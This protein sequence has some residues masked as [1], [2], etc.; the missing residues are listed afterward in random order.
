MAASRTALLASAARS[1][2]VSQSVRLFSAESKVEAK[3]AKAAQ[4]A[5]KKETAKKVKEATEKVNNARAQ[6]AQEIKQKSG[7][8]E[9]GESKV[10]SVFGSLAPV[11]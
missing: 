5:E 3:E 8:K 7:V 4:T 10:V 9:Q 6:E 1:S 11:I 2:A